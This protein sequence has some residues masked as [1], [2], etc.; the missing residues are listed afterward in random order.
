MIH[1]KNIEYKYRAFGDP[2]FQDFSLH[3]PKGKICGLLGKNGVGKSTLL[4]LISGLLKTQKGQIYCLGHNPSERDGELLQDV[5]IVPEEFDFPAISL[6]Q[7]IKATAPFYPKFDQHL[8]EQC[9][10]NFELT[11]DENLGRLSMGQKKKVYMCFA[12]ATNARLLLMDEPTNGMDIPSKSQF[13]KVISQG[14]TDDRTILISTHQVKDVELLLDQI[15]ILDKNQILVNATV[16]QITD[17]LAFEVCSQTPND[18][19]YSQPTIMGQAVVRPNLS[20]KD[21]DIDLELL[22]NATITHPEA[23]NQLK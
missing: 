7:Y 18:A 16:N 11:M 15:I 12:I 14:M 5:F 22:F 9:L 19:I 3:I 6:R 23:M 20:R 4:Y 2:V 21:T 10:Q 8:L 1:V 13:R 17:K